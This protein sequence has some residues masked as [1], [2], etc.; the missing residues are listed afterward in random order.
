MS[1]TNELDGLFRKHDLWFANDGWQPK[2]KEAFIAELLQVILA[3][4]PDMR[5]PEHKRGE[6]ITSP[7]NKSVDIIHLPK[8]VNN[9]YN[10]AV[11]EWEN[12]IK[13]LFEGG[14]K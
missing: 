5:Y 14:E 10:T 2:H 1:T 12:N 13:A 8:A 3:T 6:V 7:D 4:K 11:R 9:G